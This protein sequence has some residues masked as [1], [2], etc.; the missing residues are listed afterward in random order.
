RAVHAVFPERDKRDHG[1]PA[2][3]LIAR[4]YG[5]V[6]ARRHRALE[7]AVGCKEDFEPP[8][9]SGGR[10]RNRLSLGVQGPGIIATD[11]IGDPLFGKE[12]KPGAAAPGRIVALYPNVF[13][14]GGH[15]VEMNR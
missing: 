2:S 1:H 12:R 14:S 11:E 13:L 7:E 3:I 9:L 15:R 6:G 8:Q 5:W 4:D 10:L